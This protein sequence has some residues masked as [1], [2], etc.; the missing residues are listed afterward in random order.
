MLP[1]NI[2]TQKKYTSKCIRFIRT[3]RSLEN[4]EE[5]IDSQDFFSWERYFTRLLIDQTEESYL[6][7]KKTKLNE[8]YLHEKNK[9]MILKAIE[10]VVL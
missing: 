10:G 6:K 9:E 5:Y 4:P 1:E 7:Y 3:T 8:T 2:R